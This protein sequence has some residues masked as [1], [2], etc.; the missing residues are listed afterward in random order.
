[1]IVVPRASPRD[2]FDALT[3]QVVA[4]RGVSV[5]SYKRGCLERRIAARMRAR[6]AEDYR[7]Y[8]QVLRDDPAEYDAL[9]DALTIN[10]THLFRD[11]DVWEGVVERVLPAL[12]DSDATPI[13]TW[14]A[15]CASGEEAYTVAALWHR[16][17]ESRGTL[18]AL[19]RV[20]IT[21][22]DL[23]PT[24]LAAARTGRY[25]REAFRDTP[26]HVRTRYFSPEEPHLAA[27]ELRTMIRFE[28]R[29]LLVSAP[30]T[31]SMH[32]ITCRNVLIYFDKPSQDAI[33]GRFH[34]ALAPGGFLV[35]G[36]AESL[37][38]KSRHLFDAV[39]VQRRLFQRR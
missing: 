15:G 20:Q 36:K 6:G 27:G 23:D 16:Y 34:E 1:M 14:I 33:F 29:D 35:L 11:T 3:E 19:G 12:W 28:Q 24:A 18:A 21:A 10:V 2:P 9:L 17:I 5:S 38:G 32:L 31:G 39:D 4:A 26:V 22:S 7:A 8:A 30:P 37:L 13:N 25:P